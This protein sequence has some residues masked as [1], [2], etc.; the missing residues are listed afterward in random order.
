MDYLTAS[1]SKNTILVL[2]SGSWGS[3]LGIHLAKIHKTVYLWGRNTQAIRQ[4]QQTGINEKYLPNIK[5]PSNLIAV[6]DYTDIIQSIDHILIAVPSHGFGELLI[7]IKPYLKTQSILWATKGLCCQSHRLLSDIA[8]EVLPKT[9]NYGIITGPSF[10]KE[11]AQ[12]LPTAIVIASENQAFAKEMQNFW[13]SHYFRVYISS[14]LIGAQI[15]GAVKNALAIAVG[16]SD[17]LGFG[18]NAKAALITRGLVEI[19][20]LGKKLGAEDET[21]SGLSCLGDLI[22]TCTDDQSRNRRFGLML[23]QGYTKDQALEKIGQVV[24]GIIT[25]QAIM[26][27]SEKYDVE[28]PIVKETY[29]VLYHHKKAKDAVIHLMQRKLRN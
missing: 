12:E 7:N 20:R 5:L 15:G 8:K 10:A 25:S 28:M 26:A 21:L 3:A 24:E 2:G 11:V 17:G 18:S 29:D 14:D 23:G 6:D 13:N 4:I 1:Q 19:T 16:I 9:I 22:L 27:L